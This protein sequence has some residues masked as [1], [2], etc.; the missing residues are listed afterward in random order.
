MNVLGMVT[1][2]AVW[3]FPLY[4]SLV[5]QTD[6]NEGSFSVVFFVT[7]AGICSYEKKVSARF[8]FS[9]SKAVING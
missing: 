7:Q 3:H 9:T 2:C 1:S 6:W 8:N 4:C 5:E